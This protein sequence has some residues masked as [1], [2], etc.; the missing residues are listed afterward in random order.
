MGE[1]VMKT[2]DIIAS[3]GKLPMSELSRII[4]YGQALL[5]GKSKRPKPKSKRDEATPKVRVLGLHR[6]AMQM[7]PD[8]DD[9]LPESF[10][11]GEDKE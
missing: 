1:E 10:W 7:A 3:L 5:G 11:L 2:E 8:F 6:G 4:D 9:P